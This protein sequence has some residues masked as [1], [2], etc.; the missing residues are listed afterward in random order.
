[1]SKVSLKNKLL[2]S[3]EPIEQ[4]GTTAQKRKRAAALKDASSSNGGDN[5]PVTKKSKGTSI[6]YIGISWCCRDTFILI[7]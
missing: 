3:F 5:Q 2:P 4:K 1:M 6:L 7:N